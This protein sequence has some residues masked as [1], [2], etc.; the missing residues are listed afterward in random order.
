MVIPTVP[1]MIST[2]TPMMIF[3]VTPTTIPKTYNEIISKKK[4]LIA[5]TITIPMA[6][7][8]ISTVTSTTISITQ[9]QQQLLWR[10]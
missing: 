1:I 3:M 10:F 5:S 9:L 6:P 8:M 2:T 7:M 4:T